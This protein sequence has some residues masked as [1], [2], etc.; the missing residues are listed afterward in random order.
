[1]FFGCKY[2]GR[3]HKTA[4]SSSKWPML[5]KANNSY[6]LVCLLHGARKIIVVCTGI[7]FRLMYHIKINNKYYVMIIKIPLNRDG[8]GSG[9]IY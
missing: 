6:F 9:I 4:N 3:R 2:R 8:G 7:D 5:K 1:V